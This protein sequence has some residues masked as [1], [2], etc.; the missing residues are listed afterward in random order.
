[1]RDGN[2][3]HGV[4]HTHKKVTHP[5]THPHAHTH[6]HAHTRTCTHPTRLDIWWPWII[7]WTDVCSNSSATVN[8]YH[9][10]KSLS[11]C[12]WV[13]KVGFNNHT[14]IGN[15]FLSIVFCFCPLGVERGSTR[16]RIFLFIFYFFVWRKRDADCSPASLTASEKKTTAVCIKKTWDLAIFVFIS[17]CVFGPGDRVICQHFFQS[18]HLLLASPFFFLLAFLESSTAA[19]LAKYS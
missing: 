18:F 9:N 6:T 4:H 3:C 8:S 2:C 1:M 15:S 5:P 19:F 7:T 14:G 17:V 16:S 10:D 12:H 13:F 11:F